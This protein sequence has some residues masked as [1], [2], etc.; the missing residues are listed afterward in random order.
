MR[1]ARGDAS[2]ARSSTPPY[3]ITNYPPLYVMAQVPFV[4]AFG[5][6][7]GTGGSSR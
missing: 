2:T 3:T 6:A 1:L 4:R 7:C 5:A